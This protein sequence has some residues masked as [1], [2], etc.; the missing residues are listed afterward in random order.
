M[1]KVDCMHSRD[2][3][4]SI[5]SCQVLCDITKVTGCM[6][7]NYNGRHPVYRPTLDKCL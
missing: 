1:G 6:P 7:L 4:Q 3:T 2:V 5:G